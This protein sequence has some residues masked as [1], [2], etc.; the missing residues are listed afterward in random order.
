MLRGVL[1]REHPL[2]VQSSAVRRLCRSGDI[3][4]AEPRELRGT[5][6]HERGILGGREQLAR[7]RIPQCR[8]F[9]VERAELHLVR[10]RQV[11]AGTHEPY[12]VSLDEVLLLRTESAILAV[13]VDSLDAREELGVEIYRI[14]VSSEL[15]GFLASDTL[16]R[17][18]CIR[19]RESAEDLLNS[20][21]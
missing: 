2:A 11:R 15:R 13:I 17:G 4:R 7:E 18:I 3:R 6:E 10:L 12:V 21:K 14:A 5:V 20:A 16:Q 1:Q 19:L 8:F 9:L